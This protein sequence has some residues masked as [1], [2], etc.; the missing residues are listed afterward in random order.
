[1]VEPLTAIERMKL[2]SWQTGGKFA[3]IRSM[4]VDAGA[5]VDIGMKDTELPALAKCWLTPMELELSCM[6]PAIWSNLK[7]VM[8]KALDP[9][10]RKP[11]FG[12]IENVGNADSVDIEDITKAILNASGIPPIA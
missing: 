5:P 4:L 2:A 6:P 9:E 11:V 1:M 12:C 7:L 10:T 8:M 3:I